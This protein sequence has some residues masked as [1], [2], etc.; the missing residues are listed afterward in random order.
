MIEVAKAVTF[1]SEREELLLVQRSE[2]DT[3]PLK[4]EFP[5]G[6]V[7]EGETAELTAVRELQEE[8]GLEPEKVE[9]ASVE[10]VVIDDR[11]FRFHIFL[12]E[13]SSSEVDLSHEHESHEWA[14]I[15]ETENFDTIDSFKL[16]ME[17]VNL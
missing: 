13:V 17:A 7:D 9:K 5:G 14:S 15:E 4:W 10:E 16:Y 8:T 3:N 12:V 2:D 1:H 11:D 6:G